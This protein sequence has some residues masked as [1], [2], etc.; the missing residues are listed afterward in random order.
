MSLGEQKRLVLPQSSAS[1]RKRGMSHQTIRTYWISNSKVDPFNSHL[2]LD[3]WSL[4]N[5]GKSHARSTPD[6]QSQYQKPAWNN[7]NLTFQ[8]NAETSQGQREKKR[9]IRREK[10]IHGHRPTPSHQ[11]RHWKGPSR[12]RAHIG[13]SQRGRRM[14]CWV[15]VL[16]KW[17]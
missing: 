9:Q 16:G 3:I 10:E 2:I 7:F 1:S 15:P 11:E 13:V 4:P 14:P 8:R 6:N 12:A 17:P 5:L